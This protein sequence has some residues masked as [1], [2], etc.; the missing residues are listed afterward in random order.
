M[1]SAGVFLFP[2]RDR[3]EKATINANYIHGQFVAGAGGRCSC[4]AGKKFVF[5]QDDA[6]AHGAMRTQEWLG[7]HC[8]DFTDKNS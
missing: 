1:A 8:P 5:Q 3:E 6:S 7:E 4:L 2:L